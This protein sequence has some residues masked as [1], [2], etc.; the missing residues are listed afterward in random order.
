MGATDKMR[1]DCASRIL[2]NKRGDGI[3]Q[4]FIS[5]DPAKIEEWAQRHDK[6]GWGVFDCHNPLKAGATKRNKE[7]I[8]AVAEIYVDVD[9]KDINE[10]METVDGLLRELLITPTEIRNSGRGRHVIYRLKEAISTDDAA[11]I[12]RVDTVRAKLTDILCGDRQV[13]HHAALRRR[14]GTH[15]TKDGAWVLCEALATGNPVDL[16]EIEDMVAIYDR[17]L[18]TRKAPP[19][20]TIY[21]DFGAGSASRPPVDADAELAAMRYQ[22]AGDTGINATWW[23]RMGSLLRHDISVADTIQRLHAA[24]AANCQDDPNKSN[25][26]RTLAGMAERWLKHEPQ[27]LTALDAGLYRGWQTA[28]AAGKSPRLIWRQDFGLQ[29]RGYA[30]AEP[31]SLSAAATGDGATVTALPQPETKSKLILPTVIPISPLDLPPRQFL[32]NKHY[33]RRTVSGTV[34][35]GGTGKSSLMLVEAISMAT[36]RNLLDDQPPERVRVWYHNGEDPREEINRRMVAICEYFKIPM[37]ELTDWLFVTSGNEVPLKVAG[38]YNNFSIDKH[39]IDKISEAIGDYK[40]DAASFDPLVTLHSTNENDTGKMDAVV[41]IFAGLGDYHNCAIALAAHTRKMP[42]GGIGGD[43]RIDD[44]RGAGAVKD[45]MRL[46]RILNY[47]SEKEAQDAGIEAFERGS[48]FRVDNAKGNYLPPPKKA[49]WRK[50]VNV[51]LANLDEV[52]VIVPWVFPGAD[53]PPSPEKVAADLR[54]EHIF[55]ETLQRLN[56]AGRF[57]NERGGRGHAPPTIAKEKEAKQAK[58]GKAA[59]EE[60]MRRLFEK[61]TIRVETYGPPSHMKSKIVVV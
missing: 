12:E 18:F 55:L 30:A 9:P 19:D 24:A 7:T 33:Q 25:W 22:G 54:A 58:I 57:V 11:M 28:V 49:T 41:R 16:T 17:S 34:A 31:Q 43:Y 6:P 48:Y 15:N 26:M 32:F 60:A 44:M 56:L 5:D 35:P 50:F 37:A 42:A 1:K 27:F 2:P 45:A 47:I 21:I 39:L 53:A 4:E 8:A 61:E 23:R 13:C 40:V 3:P 46:V 20:N 51:M 59:L 38:G 14:V 52:G 29:V 10:S 36:G